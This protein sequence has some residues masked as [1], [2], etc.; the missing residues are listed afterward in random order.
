MNNK[1]AQKRNQKMSKRMG[2]EQ[3]VVA[4][5]KVVDNVSV[6]DNTKRTVEKEEE[7][8]NSKKTEKKNR[9]KSGKSVKKLQKIN[10][11]RLMVEM[12]RAIGDWDMIKDG[13]R[14]LVGVSGGKDSLTLLHLLLALQKKAPIKFD[15]GAVTVDPGT[16][17]FDPRPLIPYMKQL[18]TPHCCCFRCIRKTLTGSWFF[19]FSLSSSPFY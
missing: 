3:N 4:A 10:K 15:I 7:H 16:E 12:G 19:F 13:D 18:G 14:I 5:A 9:N 1:I 6:V 2:N 8:K 17:A 11:R